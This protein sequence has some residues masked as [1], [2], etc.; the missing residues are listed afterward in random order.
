VAG[1]TTRP[2][3]GAGEYL[4]AS[5]L[6][7]GDLNAR[8]GFRILTVEPFRDAG[9]AKIRVTYARANGAIAERVY[10]EGQLVRV[11]RQLQAQA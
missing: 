9:G 11:V 8:S 7:P 3:G 2:G 5:A 10:R 4:R 6:R 1:A